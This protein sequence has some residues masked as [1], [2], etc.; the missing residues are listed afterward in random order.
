MIDRIAPSRRPLRSIAG[1]QRWRSLLFMHW[2]VPVDKLRQL[3]PA[4]LELDLY[5]G[6]AHVG[7]V[8]FKMEGV[9]ARWW[10][11]SCEMSFL[12]TNLRTYVVCNGRPG[13]YFFS[14]EASSRLAV[15][16]ARVG[17]G[18]PY[19][20]ARSSAQQ[21][22]DVTEYK[23]RRPGSGVSH[24][25]RYRIGGKLG[26]S[27]PGTLEHFFLERYLLF[28]ERRGMIYSGQV[29]HLPYPAFEAAV[30]DV[31]DQ[32]VEAAGLLALTTPPAFAHF[33]PGV[34]VD[35][36]PLTTVG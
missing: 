9:R 21:T 15:L 34:D 26:P 28:V 18:L 27:Q 14:L 31:R 30:L 20:Y 29:H 22:D 8:P 36:F 19:F 1:F 25:V 5:D 35:V 17:W 33:S 4:G 16:G 12:E 23:T 24:T 13:I 11:E 2:V 3:V 7:I 10:P 32:L 6:K